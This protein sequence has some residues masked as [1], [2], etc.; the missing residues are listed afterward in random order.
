[1]QVMSLQK[2]AFSCQVNPYEL[3]WAVSDSICAF[4]NLKNYNFESDI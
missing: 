4:T 3:V 2:L 1:M